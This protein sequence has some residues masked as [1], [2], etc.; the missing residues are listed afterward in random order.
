MWFGVVHSIRVIDKKV[1]FRYPVHVIR[2]SWQSAIDRLSSY[3][4]SW[5]DICDKTFNSTLNF[6][7]ELSTDN[8]QN[9]RIT[10]CFQVSIGLVN[11]LGLF[12]EE[13]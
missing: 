5:L 12:D 2:F 9:M 8:I 6:D 11:G 3:L 4:H 13:A 1:K 10:F 7:L